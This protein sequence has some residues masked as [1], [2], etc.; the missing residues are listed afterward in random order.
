MLQIILLPVNFTQASISMW[1]HELIM[2]WWIILFLLT[3]S[4]HFKGLFYLTEGLFCQKCLN[5]VFIFKTDTLCCVSSGNYNLYS[6]RHFGPLW[7]LSTYLRAV[8][9]AVSL[10]CIISVF[11]DQVIFMLHKNRDGWLFFFPPPP[12][13]WMV[14]FKLSWSHLNP[15]MLTES[16]SMYLPHTGFPYLFMTANTMFL[17]RQK[18]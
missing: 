9:L 12:M 8:K 1:I 7:K 18:L 14:S 11:G 13:I 4:P 16:L 3:L 5:C 17:S 6:W 15:S 10:P 2:V